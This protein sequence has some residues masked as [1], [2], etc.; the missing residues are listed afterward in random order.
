MSRVETR[1]KQKEKAL[2]KK[3]DAP[4][5]SPELITKT[6]PVDQSLIKD[7]DKDKVYEGSFFGIH[8]GYKYTGKEID[9]AI[10]GQFT[11]E[12]RSDATA[13]QD[14][15]GSPSPAVI[16]ETVTYSEPTLGVR[17]VVDVVPRIDV[18]KLTQIPGLGVE[19]T[20]GKDYTD[21]CFELLRLASDFI[22][23]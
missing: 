9:D 13:F 12:S 16:E 2:L 17:S 22:F 18:S 1:Q 6:V 10:Y 14:A 4:V 8:T 11:G 23:S 21:S 3:K 15:Y 7:E 19:N 20:F 5:E